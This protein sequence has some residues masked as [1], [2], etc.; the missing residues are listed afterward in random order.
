MTDDEIKR[1]ST[2]DI[3]IELDRCVPYMRSRFLLTTVPAVGLFF[4]VAL[5]KLSFSNFPVTGAVGVV[6]VVLPYLTVATVVFLATWV[7]YFGSQARG[8]YKYVSAL[9][10]EI[11]KRIARS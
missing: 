3:E 6:G 8:A 4:M 5:L 10:A 2:H 7:V 9:R 11:G 1:S